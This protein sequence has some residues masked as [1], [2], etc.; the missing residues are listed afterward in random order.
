MKPASPS[1]G[2]ASLVPPDY[3]GAVIQLCVAKRGVQKRLAYTGTQVSLEYDLPL[4]E[5]VMDFFDRLKSVSRGHASFDYE[6]DRF[7]PGDLVR[8]DVLINHERVDALSLIVHRES[9][10]S[11]RSGAG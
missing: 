7:E 1:S 6:F 5:I 4:A 3:L 10:P 11:A 8:L 2:P 9:S